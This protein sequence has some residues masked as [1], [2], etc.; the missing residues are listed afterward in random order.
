MDKDNQGALDFRQFCMGMYLINAFQSCLIP[1]IPTSI[2]QEL[3]DKFLDVQLLD[4]SSPAPPLSR[5][6]S[7]PSQPPIS[8]GITPP[9]SLD[10]AAF[11]SFVDN[12]EQEQWDILPHEKMEADNHF[13]Q[14]DPDRKGYIETATAAKF[15]MGYDLPQAELGRIWCVLHVA[16][17]LNT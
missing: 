10:T 17:D 11:S 3:Y 9:T 2:P 15:L 16:L 7:S 12:Q 4:S 6:A 5:S 14:L 13:L 1:T 8:P